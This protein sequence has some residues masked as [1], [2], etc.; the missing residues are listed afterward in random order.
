MPEEA[1]TTPV[2]IEP[3]GKA[4]FWSDVR[5]A[6]AGRRMDYTSIPIGRA[7]LLLAV[8]MVLEMS[9]QS[10]FSVA[11]VYFVGKLGSAAVAVVGVT[12][13]FLTLVFAVAIGLSMGTTAMV[14]RRVG[15]GDDEGASKATGQAILL[16]IGLSIPVAIV[17]V[18]LARDLLVWMGVEAA[19]ASDGASFTAIIL[20]GNV[21]VMLLFLINAAFRG[22]GDPALAMRALWIA[23]ALNIALDP[24]LIFGWGPIPAMGL[25][26][27]AVATTLGRGVGVI[28]QLWKL[29]HPTSHLQLDWRKLRVVPEVM[30]RLARVSG[31]GVL[32]YLVSTA[33]FL[34]L[35]RFLAIFGEAALAGYT[36]AV[37]VIIFVLLPAW[38]MGNA[39]ATLV[40]QNLGAGDPARAERS[41]WLTALCNAVFLAL[42]TVALIAWG[43]P[44]VL[45]FS[46]EPAVVEI[47]ASCLRIVAYSY[48]FWGYG[49]IAV[50]A[51]N[52]AGD[53]TTPTWLHF[54]AYWVVQIP[55]AWVLAMPLGWGEDGIFWSIAIGQLTIAVIGVLAFRRGSWKTREI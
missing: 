50:L 53:T 27:A 7:I 22:A 19:A 10:L 33:S 18:W 6:L 37:R 40:G 55:L 43:E 15:E 8:P 9:M 48:V 20:G 32:Q 35:I 14:A 42:V 41:V 23:N 39:A 12:D 2:A 4:G 46:R 29:T 30:L 26:G 11:D 34:A 38:G 13:Q 5:G 3:A 45:V 28:Y 49:M 1:S 54:I 17:G 44:I 52:G 51:F 16:G 24:L 31:I 36:I 21:T 25:A 47:A